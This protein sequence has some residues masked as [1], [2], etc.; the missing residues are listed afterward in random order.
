MKILVLQLLRMGDL[1]MMAPLFAALKKRY[2]ESEIHLL[3]NDSVVSVAQMIPEVDQIWSFERKKLQRSLGEAESAFFSAFDQLDDLVNQLD[4][5][6]FDLCLNL[7]QNRLSGYLLSLL[8]IE[9]KQGMRLDSSGRVEF[10]SAWL[11]LLNSRR[12]E[13]QSPFHFVDTFRM[14]VNLE[15]AKPCWPESQ[16]GQ[17]EARSILGQVGLENF[18]AVQ[19]L[20]SDVKKNW[21]LSSWQSCLEKLVE[22]NVDRSLS[23]LFLAAPNEREIVESFTMRL[24]ARG[25]RAEVA[26]CSMSGAFSLLKKAQLLITGDTSIKH[27]GAVCGTPVFELALGSSSFQ[28]TGVYQHH[29]LI[30]RSTASC[31]P[32]GHRES[33]RQDSF[34][35]QESVSPEA[36]A[37][38]LHS[39]LARDWPSLRRIAV[40]FKEKMEV[41]RVDLKSREFWCYENLSLSQREN[42]EWWLYQTSEGLRVYREEEAPYRIG[43]ET[44]EM[45]ELLKNS[46]G[47]SFEKAQI[48]RAQEKS[49]RTNCALGS[50]LIEF[51]ELVANM[52]QSHQ[53]VRYQKALDRFLT[54]V[55]NYEGLLKKDFLQ[56]GQQLQDMLESDGSEK[57]GFFFLARQ[58]QDRTNFW[59][60]QTETELDILRG[61][62]IFERRL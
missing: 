8:D 31:A 48:E 36:V 24:R 56:L 17:A 15:A 1:I 12:Y 39:Y 52:E 4:S 35:C 5:E 37:M 41:I 45:A 51:K 29:S 42:L 13:Q 21:P 32:C 16:E 49:E 9:E 19:L 38:A 22:L 11:R 58:L 43:T 57:T 30:L 14:G 33:C 26:T 18:I 59:K 61:L 34:I 7:T 23:F 46:Y 53:W 20:T 3:V 50:L 60:E 47:G 62:S 25:I 54:T 44:Y 6:D 2:P 40:E 28:Q 55:E 27:L 10:S